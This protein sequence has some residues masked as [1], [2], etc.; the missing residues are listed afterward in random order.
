M[1]QAE[2]KSYNS[3]RIIILNIIPKATRAT[4]MYFEQI[5]IFFS[6]A[7]PYSTEMIGEVII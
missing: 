3:E 7:E 6:I 2:V 1:N 5:I 4:R